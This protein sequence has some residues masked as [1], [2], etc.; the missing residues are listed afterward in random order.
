MKQE[1]LRLDQ[2]TVVEQSAVELNHFSLEIFAGEIMGLIP[3]SGTGLPALLRLLR[4][5]LPLHYGYVY[6]RE[7]RVNQW[8]HSDGSYNRIGVIETRSGLAEDLTVADNVFVLRKGFKKHVIQRGM[9][10]RALQPFLQDIDVE[11]SANAYAK[12]LSAFQRFVVEIVKA[13]VAGCRLII[14]ND[15]G[16]IVSDM[17]L[18]KLQKILRHYVQE[19]ISFLYVSRHYEEIRS[20]CDR[21]AFMYN[22]Q[23]TKVLSTKETEPSMI[24]SFGVETFEQL[25]QSAHR[26][27]SQTTAAALSMQ[28]LHTG[29]ISGLDLTIAT[30]ECVVVQDLENHIFNDLLA[31]LNLEK[32]PAQG[33]VWVGGEILSHQNRREVAIIQRLA[34]KTMIFPE[35]SYMDNLCF[36]MD[37]Q[38]P[39]V[40]VSAQAKAGIRRECARWLGEDVFFKH[41]EELTPLEKYDLIY[42]R[43]LLQRPKA[44]FCVQPFMQAD[45]QQRIHIWQWIERLLE[46]DIAVVILAINL[47]DTLSLADRLVRIQNGQVLAT[48]QRSEFGALP[49]NPPWQ[50]LWS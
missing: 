7:K 16:T 47:A 32:K 46:K 23:I 44:V 38:L 12:D 19:G 43:V 25:V 1:I 8:Q 35:L 15:A 24:H 5:N 39:K 13:V 34:T 37:H 42:S 18:H 48:Y 40:W 3:I 49:N 29:V 22:G 2:V 21:A 45:V 26:P 4:Q 6:Y 11:I 9:L 14:L 33:T 20:I 50:H 27:R 10:G 41:T 17:E 31:I 28:G 30:G 36:A